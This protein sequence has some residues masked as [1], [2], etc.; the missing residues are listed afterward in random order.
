MFVIIELTYRIRKINFRESTSSR[1]NVKILCFQA[2][3]SLREETGSGGRAL[4]E[5]E[6]GDQGQ[7]TQN[8]ATKC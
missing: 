4:R 1:K 7:S 2:V 6:D 8:T 3:R 5:R